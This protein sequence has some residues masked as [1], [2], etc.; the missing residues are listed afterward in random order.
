LILAASEGSAAWGTTLLATYTFGVAIPFLLIGLCIKY[1]LN[2]LSHEHKY[3]RYIYIFSGL[4]LVVLG[5]MTAL[6]KLNVI[7]GLLR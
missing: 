4:F 2:Y 3:L 1:F 7:Y 5:L 6:N